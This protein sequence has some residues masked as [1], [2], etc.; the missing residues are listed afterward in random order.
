MKWSEGVIMKWNL[1]RGRRAEAD[2]FVLLWVKVRGR[3]R[4]GANK[5]F[6]W[7][8]KNENTNVVRCYTHELS[9]QVLLYVWLGIPYMNQTITVPYVHLQSMSKV[10]FHPEVSL[11]LMLVH[12]IK[13][14]GTVGTCALLTSG[15]PRV[16]THGRAKV[17]GQIWLIAVI[18]MSSFWLWWSWLTWSFVLLKSIKGPTS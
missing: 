18:E 15:C 2:V 13:T 9:H 10:K 1:S 11:V 8:T 5:W 7:W 17:Y 3:R 4:E 14:H 12:W 6:G 16:Y